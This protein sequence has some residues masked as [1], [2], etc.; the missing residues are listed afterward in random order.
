MY[1]CM[2]VCMYVYTYIYIYIYICVWPTNVRGMTQPRRVAAM[3]AAKRM[4]TY[5]DVC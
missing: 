1:V 3:P 5:A 4:L 2:Y